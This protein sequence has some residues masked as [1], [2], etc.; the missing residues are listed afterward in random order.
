VFWFF[1]LSGAGKST[2]ADAAAGLL[3]SQGRA[4]LTLDGDALR[5]GLCHGLGFSDADRA[6]NLRRAAEAAKLG[7]NSGLCVIASFITP[8]E[9]HRGIVAGILGPANVSFI[10]VSA[11]LDTCRARDT[12]GLYARATSGQVAH[13]TGLSSAFE[14]PRAADL[15]ILTA[16]EEVAASS[17]KVMQFI[18][19]RPARSR[20]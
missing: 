6:E 12:K 4:V 15:T 20:G 5:A 19:E 3:R 16:Q 18:R 1:G 9:S 10:H 13:M 14:A 17:A 11:P 8:L 2:L 7:I